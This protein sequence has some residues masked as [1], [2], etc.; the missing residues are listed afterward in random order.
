VVAA[1]LALVLRPE[2]WKRLALVAVTTLVCLLVYTSSLFSVSAFF[3]FVSLLERR[4]ALRLLAVLFV[5]GL[6]AVGW[7][8]WPFLIA[9]FTEILPALLTGGASSTGAGSS[10][11]GHAFSRIPLFYGYLFPLL[12]V[13][14]LI[15]SGRRA[16]PRAFRLLAAYA[17]AFALMLALRAFGGGIFKDLKEIMFAAP[18][19]AMLAGASL[20]ALSKRGVWGKLATAALVV[21]LSIFGLGRYRTYLGS[22]QS[23]VTAAP[24]DSDPSRLL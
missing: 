19:V 6:V 13:F 2:S 12:A 22:Y 18:L 15:V 3:L 21:A 23:P 11:V 9:L 8:Y 4:L 20:D 7:L 5:S 10:S 16:D 17:L 24:A 14:G 1:V